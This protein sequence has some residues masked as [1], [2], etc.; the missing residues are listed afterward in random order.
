MEIETTT[1]FDDDIMYLEPPKLIRQ[2]GYTMPDNKGNIPKE[3]QNVEIVQNDTSIPKTD[4]VKNDII[5]DN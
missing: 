5:I 1:I 4:I 2:H 3:D